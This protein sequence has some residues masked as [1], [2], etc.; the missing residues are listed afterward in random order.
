MCWLGALLGQMP[1]LALLFLALAAVQP[2]PGQAISGSILGVATDS[3]GALVADARVT[4]VNTGTGLNQTVHTGHQGDYLVPNLPPGLYAVTV[5]KD[6]FRTLHRTSLEISVDQKLRLDVTLSVGDLREQVTVEGR[7]PLLQTQ[8]VETGQVIQSRQ[9]LDLP[10]LGRNFLDLASLI[11][12]VAAG[13]GGNIANYSVNGQREFA[14]SIL[15]NGFEV[16]GNRNND[17]N[18]RPSVDSV[19]EFKAVTSTYAPEFGR[20]GGGVFAVQTKSGTNDFHGSLYEFLRTP[21]TTARSPFAQDPSGLKQNNFGVSVGGPIVRNR[22]FFFAGY[23]GLRSRDIFSYL[24]TTVPSQM[25]GYRADGSVDLSKLIDPYTGK[26]IPIYDPAFYNANF[27]SEQ[28]PGNVI[29]ASRVSPA[30]RQILQKLFPAPNVPGIFNGWFN[31]FDVQQRYR[32]DSNTG[33]LRVDHQFGN[34]DR[35][36]LTYDVVAFNSLTG[37][38]FAGAIPVSGGGSADSADATNSTNQ[39]AGITYTHIFN[40]NQFNELHFSMV[41]VT[42]E[43]NDLL[44]GSNLATQFGIAN[45]N[46]PGFPQTDG[47]PQIQLAFGPTAGGS[48]YKP[49]TF[50]DH[51]IQVGDNFSWL[52]GK[53][54]FKFG[55]EYR[56][57]VAHPDFSLFP[58]GYQYYNGAYA[59]LTSDPNYSSP[60]YNAYYATGGN[61]IAD[62]LLGLPG[63]VA[64]GLQLT[65]PKTTSY[66]Q[67]FY[68]QDAWQIT[69][70]LVL[71]Y[72]VR[73]EYQAPYSEANN[74]AANFDPATKTMLLAGRGSNLSSLIQPDKN[75]FAPRL[76]IAWQLAPKTVIR[77]GYGIYYTPEN[78]A[79]SDI[80]SKNYPF[81]IQQNFSNSPGTPFSYILDT[82]IAR[83]TSVPISPGASSIDLTTIPNAST[84]ERLF[85]R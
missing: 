11:P 63:F 38:P 59:S 44:N 42:L 78:D 82:G 47:F 73:Y 65:N 31:N 7:A 10:L 24:D 16:T 67:H 6:G 3:S 57:L 51:N 37:D 72:G 25:I 70:K 79:R 34:N 46:I 4:V 54:S 18:L 40:P 75:N 81:F 60:D 33:D 35:V 29:P 8:S 69:H 61:E 53:H 36:S 43:Q 19:E 22:T 74:N 48:T 26:Q 2:L 45:A 9:I 13:A 15:V 23:E 83:P 21:A 68:V 71:T 55:Y 17:T 58:A 84:A 62:L 76:G 27:F 52:T 1:T 50:L 5:E 32:F 12:G 30:G 77:T 80:L 20:S 64:Q 41:H 39:N 49:L 14:N 56:N 28:F 66:E 85:R